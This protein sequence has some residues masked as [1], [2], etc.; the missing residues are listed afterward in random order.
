M[1]VIG[2]VVTAAKRYV[3][4]RIVRSLGRFRERRGLHAT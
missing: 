1:I 4:R 3:V 2:Y